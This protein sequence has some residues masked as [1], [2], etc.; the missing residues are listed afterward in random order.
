MLHGRRPPGLPACLLMAVAALA[1]AAAPAHAVICES[2]RTPAECAGKVTSSGRCG[3]EGGACR[4][5]A[6]LPEGTAAVTSVEEPSFA[7]TEAEPVQPEA[8]TPAAEGKAF[9]RRGGDLP[10][11]QPLLDPICGCL[12]AFPCTAVLH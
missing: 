11:C 9:E 4:M 3:W 8:A 5:V 10:G 12:C 1:L 2:F 6:P 7:I